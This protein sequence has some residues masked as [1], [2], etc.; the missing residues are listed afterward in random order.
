MSRES[1][2][3][4]GGPKKKKEIVP[5]EKAPVPELAKP[6][7]EEEKP[8]LVPEQAGEMSREN[9]IDY[10]NKNIE[11]IRLA[12]MAKTVREDVASGIGM[13]P[14]ASLLS[15]IKKRYLKLQ[16]EI[17]EV[18]WDLPTGSEYKD[19][20]T[21][22]WF[23]NRLKELGVEPNVQVLKLKGHR[24]KTEATP[25]AESDVGEG[26]TTTES[27]VAP[28]PQAIS[29]VEPVIEDKLITNAVKNH[30]T[31]SHLPRDVEVFD[32]FNE[33]KF[34]ED[35]AQ[36]K[37][38]AELF[39][40]LNKYGGVSQPDGKGFVL[41]AGLVSVIE[42]MRRLF[43]EKGRI[44]EN[45]HNWLPNVG[46]LTEKV[47]DLLEKERLIGV[48]PEPQVALPRLPLSTNEA[49]PVNTP[50]NWREFWRTSDGRE[51]MGRR[52]KGFVKDKY[53]DYK[54]KGKKVW[55]PLK[56]RVF[57]VAT[58][59]WWD[60]HQANRFSTAT[61]EVGSR[62]GIEAGKIQQTKNLL[63]FDSAMEEAKE[64][65]RRADNEIED[66]GVAKEDSH[67]IWTLYDKISNQ[68]TSEK[69]R[70]NQ[71]VIKNVEAVM[72]QAK[73]DLRKRLE[74]DSRL[75]RFLK[76]DRYL[77]TNTGKQ[78]LTE[79]KLAYLEHQL[80]QRLV[81]L[82]NHTVFEQYKDFTALTREILDEKW[83][84][85]YVYAGVEAALASIASGA[86]PKLAGVTLVMNSLPK[87]K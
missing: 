47:F 59:G 19:T 5:I 17:S 72:A 76:L 13:P 40:V 1:I 9:E 56:E 14:D 22:D 60:L 20:H 7:L 53:L 18:D 25:V 2:M 44:M 31:E 28:E 77:E 85:R 32:S 24:R 4:G 52:F 38:F 80:R 27:E 50:N 51:E 70:S 54:E 48:E 55:G 26:G 83:K 82:S 63:N 41:Y 79:E 61:K 34:S 66:L 6:D 12:E 37:N 74:S 16:N 87:V 21:L 78:A 71:R 67:Q 39:A 86:L 33:K 69:E 43:A 49:P 57:G 42:E 36:T 8:V 81:F 84:R 45:W 23:I 64:L 62:F 75:L 11:F 29:T 46:G 3:L 30:S 68:I 65:S 73:A 10:L 58:F 35:I 15:R